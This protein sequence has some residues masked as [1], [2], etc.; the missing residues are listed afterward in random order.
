MKNLRTS[1]SKPFISRVGC[2]SFLNGDCDMT[3][4]YASNTV[5]RNA[6]PLPFFPSSVNR[7]LEHC[8]RYDRQSYLHLQAASRYSSR[9]CASSVIALSANLDK[10]IFLR[11]AQRLLSRSMFSPTNVQLRN[12]EREREKRVAYI[13]ISL[14]HVLFPR[15]CVRNM[16]NGVTTGPCHL[17]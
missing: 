2:K 12:R 16:V 13:V 5:R 10:A 1:S 6:Y 17:V 9:V 4:S 14:R 7:K 8:L 3:A 15:S 11:R